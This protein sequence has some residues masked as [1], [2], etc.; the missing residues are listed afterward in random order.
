MP[1]WNFTDFFHRW[2]GF[3]EGG[4]GAFLTSPLAPGVNFTPRGNVHPFI[5][6]YYLE[7][8]RGDE[9]R[10]SADGITLSAGDNFTPGVKVCP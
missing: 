9:Q 5:H 3:F 1:R 8:W 2:G 7:E 10:V 6:P 4:R